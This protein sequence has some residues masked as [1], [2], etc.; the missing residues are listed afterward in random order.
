MF[1]VMSDHLHA[2]CAIRFLQ[3]GAFLQNISSLTISGH[4]YAISV[5]E[6]SVRIG[7]LCAIEGL[8]QRNI[9]FGVRLVIGGLIVKKILRSTKRFML[10][11]ADMCAI[12]VAKGLLGKLIY[13]DTNLFHMPRYKVNL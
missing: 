3:E 8:I 10:M 7:F 6:I 4:M 1:I 2:L 9:S 5:G 11:S 13:G 12:F